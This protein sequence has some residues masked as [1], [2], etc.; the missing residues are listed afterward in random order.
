MFIYVPA[1]KAKERIVGSPLPHFGFVFK[2]AHLG[3]Y[4]RLFGCLVRAV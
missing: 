1:P 4:V 3:G 2:G